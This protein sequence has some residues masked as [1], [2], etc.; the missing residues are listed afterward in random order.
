MMLCDVFSR[1]EKWKEP[2]EAPV[3]RGADIPV[4]KVHLY[5]VAIT[6]THNKVLSVR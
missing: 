5:I 4:P 2:P 6:M 3:R 1:T